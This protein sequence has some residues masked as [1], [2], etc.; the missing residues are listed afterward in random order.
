MAKAAIG[1][2]R[3]RR[4]GRRSRIERSGTPAPA[5]PAYVTRRIPP[6]EILTEAGITDIEAATDHLLQE[7]GIEF[8]NDPETLD[9]W[10]QAGACVAGERV[11]FDKGMLRALIRQSAPRSFVQQARNPARSVKFGDGSVV[12][13]PA[14]GPPFVRSL[15]F[16]RRYGRLEDFNNFVKL[17]YL[18]PHL[19]H[20]S[21]PICEPT[22]IPVNKRHLEMTYGHIRY[23]DKPFMGA[24]TAGERAEDSLA[25][26]RIVFG[27]D[28]VAKNCV[29]IGLINVNS[30]L[31][32]DATMLDALKV[33]ARAGQ[34]V[35]VTPVIMAGATGPTTVASNLVQSLAETMAG[36]ALT[37]A[38]RPGAPVLA[39]HLSTALDMRSGA[40][41]RGAEPM[42]ALLAFG[43]LIR[44]LGI[45][46]RAGGSF[47][48]AKILDAQAMQEAA[49][50][51]LTTVMS[52]ANFVIHAAGSFESGLCASYEKLVMDADNLAIMTRLLQG[53][54]TSPDE[55][56][57]EAFR[58]VGPG[59]HFLGCAHTL[60]RYR[61]AFIHSE[62]ADTASF[63]Q[64]KEAG[65]SSAAERANRLWKRMLADY[66]APPLAPAIDEELR[67]YVARRKAGMPDSFA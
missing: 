45:P 62:I 12:F 6:H 55:C 25:M 64:W 52:G 33:Y 49:S 35:T 3:S 18:S 21:G 51:I 38:I 39:G 56:G 23:S 67:D 16:E 31:V 47:S 14:Y 1:P 50:F 29:V 32:F 46:F 9:L 43:Q 54:G 48:A 20:S 42:L 57:L 36:V 19:H 44:R 13:A 26:A 60:A 30:P 66:E 40:P 2:G 11:R 59:Q 41:A 34:A 15:D 7:I 37:Q 58:E 28:F 17:A 53:I 65:E 10:R 24:V 63:E 4:G 8:R 5:A 22:D 61:D 27:A